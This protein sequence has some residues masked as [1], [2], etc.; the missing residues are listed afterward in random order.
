MVNHESKILELITRRGPLKVRDICKLT[1]LHETSVKRFIKP[2]FTRGVLKRASDWSYSINTTPLPEESEKHLHLATQAAELEAKGFWL[3][4]AQVW[5]EAMLVAKFEAS[6]NEA[7]ENCDRCAAKGS[8]NCGSYGGLDTG[9]IIS[10]S[11][12]RDL[13]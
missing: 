13:L 1:D 7:K 10:A 8:L 2:L 12:N 11:V 5:R 3:R 4:A 6:R 9:R